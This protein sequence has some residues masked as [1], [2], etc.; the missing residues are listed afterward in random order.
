[1]PISDR[2]ARLAFILAALGDAPVRV[3]GRPLGQGTDAGD[4]YGP[5]TLV[6]VGDAVFRLAPGTPEAVAPPEPGDARGRLPRH[7]AAACGSAL[8]TICEATLPSCRRKLPVWYA[9]P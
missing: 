8:R 3:D 5:G 7:A 6:S 4:E 9:C 1:M 2:R